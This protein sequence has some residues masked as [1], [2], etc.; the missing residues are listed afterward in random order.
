MTYPFTKII[1]AEAVEKYKTY[2][3]YV[4]YLEKKVDSFCSRKLEKHKFKH[5]ISE[6]LK[7]THKERFRL[8]VLGKRN[9]GVNPLSSR[10]AEEDYAEM[11]KITETL[12]PSEQKIKELF[13]KIEELNIDR[14]R[15]TLLEEVDVAQSLFEEV[16]W[17]LTEAQFYET[18]QQAETTALTEEYYKLNSK[19]R[20][21][22]MI[23]DPQKGGKD[24]E[25]WNTFSWKQIALDKFVEYREKYFKNLEKLLESQKVTES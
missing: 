22:W 20:E 14:D 19:Q 2:E 23:P 16:V 21:C 13:D 12:K 17:K 1:I 11:D 24:L 8:L 18:A 6:E 7:R 25:L 3:N 15:K 9:R 4:V 5:E 10:N